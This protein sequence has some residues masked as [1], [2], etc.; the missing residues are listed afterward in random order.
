[1]TKR[2]ELR[3]ARIVKIKKIQSS[4]M[5]P[6]KSRKMR[7]NSVKT[8]KKTTTTTTQNKLLTRRNQGKTGTTWRGTPMRKIGK[9]PSEDSKI[10]RTRVEVAHPPKRPGD[11]Y[12][13]VT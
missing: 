4:R 5:R 13:F 10:M 9:L 11:D 1:M 2:M 8:T 7:V 12:L 6:M 3:K